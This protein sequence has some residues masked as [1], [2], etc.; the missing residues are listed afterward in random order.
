MDGVA[1]EL[2]KSA[3]SQLR[4]SQRRQFLAQVCTGLCGGNPRRAEEP[5]GWGRQPIA[6]GLAE[7][8]AEAAEQKAPKSGNRGKRRSEDENPQLM[9]KLMQGGQCPPR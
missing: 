5:F 8:Q 2:L 3:A 1:D 9:I 6:K 4:G 7:R